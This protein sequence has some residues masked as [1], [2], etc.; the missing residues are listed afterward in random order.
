MPL[1]AVLFDLDDTLHD[2][3][4]TLWRVGRRLH[5]DHR[6]DRLGV[7]VLAWEDRFVAWS[8]ERLDK[9]EVF[10][11][12][13]DRFTL[14]DTLARDLFAD[15]DA[16]LGRDAVAFPGAI[17]CLAACRAAGLKLGVVTNGRDAFQRSKL[18]GIGATPYLDA[19]FT[20]DG[21]GARKPDPAIFTACL[22]ALGC[23]PEH[24]AMVGD[25]RAHDL[26][27]AL[28]LGLRAV[29]KSPHI[30]GDIALGSDDFAVIAAWLTA[31]AHA[32]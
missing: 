19:V 5:T 14:P 6:L 15:H 26:A 22:D 20:S 17:D 30:A 13:R 4:A 8:R 27:P 32:R 18:D 11:R 2:K 3:T 16:T 21:F 10:A 9:A 7:D 31:Q 29:W 25:D 28:A 23:S 12:L 24:A 1:H